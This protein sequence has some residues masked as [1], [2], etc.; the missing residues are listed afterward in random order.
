MKNKVNKEK[1]VA[2]NN[3]GKAMDNNL[4]GYA[5]YPASDDIYSR[6]KKVTD[7]D[8]EDISHHKAPNEMTTNGKA[9]EKD[10]N[11]DPSGSDLDIPGAESDDQ[12]E[13]IGSE[14]EENNFY[15]IGGDD[16]NDLDEDNG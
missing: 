5:L 11:E 1:A 9:N 12:Q 8:P 2:E 4:S 15:S 3:E 14:D 7:I 6:S 16:H 13:D 10:F